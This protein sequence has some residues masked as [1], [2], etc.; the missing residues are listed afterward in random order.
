MLLDLREYLVAY[1]DEQIAP[2]DVNAARPA[3][4]QTWIDFPKIGGVA[5]R[6]VQAF[7]VPAIILAIWAENSHY[8]WVSPRILPP[9]SAIVNTFEAMI[10]SGDIGSNLGISLLRVLEGFLFGATLGLA[11]GIAMG[12]SDAVEAWIGPLFRFVTQIPTLVWIPLLMQLLGIDEV[13]KLVVMA[14]ACSIPITMTTS[15]GIRN[16]PRKYLEVGRVLSLPRHLLLRKIILPGAL[17]SIFTGLRQGI[18]HVWI[19][20]VIV[21]MMASTNGIGYLMSWARTLFQLD[22]VIVCIVLIG[23]IGFALDFSLRRVEVRLLRWRGG[24]A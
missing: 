17:P 19:S 24:S 16:I 5:W 4:A 14:K 22:E 7:I 23:V 1:T 10:A 18:A 13:L 9:P 6:V 20:L 21:E 15:E 3:A 8:E 11:L 12:L 2:N